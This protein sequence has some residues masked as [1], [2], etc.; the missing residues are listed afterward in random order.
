MILISSLIWKNIVFI[1]L[2]QAPPLNASQFSLTQNFFV[3]PE[4]FLNEFEEKYY[5]T[6]KIE[7]SA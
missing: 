3:A 7:K 4:E 6:H 2:K 1:C 5:K